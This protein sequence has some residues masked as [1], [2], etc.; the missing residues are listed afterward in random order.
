MRAM[1]PEKL[2]E[3]IIMIICPSITTFVYKT[4]VTTK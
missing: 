3:K 1:R 4:L 2:V